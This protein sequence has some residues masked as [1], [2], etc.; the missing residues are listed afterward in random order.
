MKHDWDF[1]MTLEVY[2]DGGTLLGSTDIS[3]D[4]TP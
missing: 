1:D 3:L 4:L 2:S